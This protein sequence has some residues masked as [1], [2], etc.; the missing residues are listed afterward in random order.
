MGEGER[1]AAAFSDPD[2]HPATDEQLARMRRVPD[3][4]A[5]RAKFGLDIEAFA[6]RFGLPPTLVRDWEEHRRPV[7]PAAKTLLR[8]IERDPD[9]VARVAAE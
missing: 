6:R 5:I 8:V 9:A 3:V 2:A 1:N 4:A 7:D